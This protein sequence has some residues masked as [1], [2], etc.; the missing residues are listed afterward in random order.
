LLNVTNDGWYGNTA[1]PYQHFAI[2]RVRAV[3]E[4][5]P[6]VRAAN[7]GISGIVDPYGRIEA[8]LGLGQRG[9]VD[10]DLPQPLPAPTFFCRYG[11]KPTWLIFVLLAVNA[12]LGK[13]LTKN[14]A[15]MK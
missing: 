13:L 9:F 8:K 4:G 1:G 2:A 5:V 11:E 10:G 6:L 15:R 14:T 7:T 12:T 3:E